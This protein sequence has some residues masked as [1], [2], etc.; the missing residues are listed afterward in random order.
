MLG[1]ARS[2]S[3]LRDV[4][5]QFSWLAVCVALLLLPTNCHCEI[6]FLRPFLIVGPESH[7]RTG[8]R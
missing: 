4:T 3:L 1:N 7:R 6:D 2:A 8:D 5:P